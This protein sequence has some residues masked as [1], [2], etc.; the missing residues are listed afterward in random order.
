L[1][2]EVSAKPLRK[3]KGMFEPCMGFQARGLCFVMIFIY[4]SVEHYW[5]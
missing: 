2:H 1:E 5:F 4:F 3:T